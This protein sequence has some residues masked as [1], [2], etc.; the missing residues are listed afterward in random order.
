MSSSF[1]LSLVAVSRKKGSFNFSVEVFG[2]CDEEEVR[3]REDE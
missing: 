3:E 2:I 1:L